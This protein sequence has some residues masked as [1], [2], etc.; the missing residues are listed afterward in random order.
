MVWHNRPQNGRFQT[1]IAAQCAP[2]ASQGAQACAVFVTRAAMA[3]THWLSMPTRSCHWGFPCGFPAIC[4]AR[5]P[6]P[7]NAL[8]LQGSLAKRFNIGVR[9]RGRRGAPLLVASPRFLSPTVI[10]A[11]HV[12]QGGRPPGPGWFRLECSSLHRVVHGAW[13]KFV[14]WLRRAVKNKSPDVYTSYRRVH[15][16]N[17]I[18]I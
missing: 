9:N 3:T 6:V 4:Q 5:A 2:H 8:Y 16:Y 17:C 1:C 13:L 14:A 12:P 15:S 18:Y 10:G 11:H 7:A